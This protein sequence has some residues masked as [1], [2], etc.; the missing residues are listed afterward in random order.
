MRILIPMAGEGSRFKKEGYS[1][2]KPA[3]KTYDRHTGELL[4]MVVCAVRD[5]PG[6]V[7][8]GENVIFVDRE[9][10]KTDGVEKEILKHFPKAKFISTNVLTEGQACTCLL[11]K[12][13]LD[14]DE[15]LLIAGCDNGMDINI[16][17]FE[18]LTQEAD[19][20]VFTYRHNEAVKKN[21]NAYG[22]MKVD[23]DEN[24]VGASIK[25]AISDNPCE[26]HAVVAT[27]WFKSADLFIKSAEQMI[28]ENDRINNE[29][30]V[31]E[32][33]KYVI[34]MGK[35]AKVF[36]IDRYV[37]WGTPTDYETFQNTYEYWKHFL[38]N[39]KMI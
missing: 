36:D 17:R 32:I 14:R 11:A 22:W 35:K 12:D 16:G 13:L 39:E 7:P 29:F 2:H 9:F 27:F 38:E 31:D 10:H 30:Y 3:I 6:V 19:E 4:P 28:A 24:I 21:P 8:N 33:V 15:S 26:D 1:V 18:K 25:K 23:T 5:L 20:I 34:G 37:G